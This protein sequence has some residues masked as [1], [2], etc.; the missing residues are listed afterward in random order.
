MLP[1]AECEQYSPT[2][3]ESNAG[4]V[5]FEQRDCGTDAIGLCLKHA[6]WQGAGCIARDK[7]II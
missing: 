5:P 1:N 7:V 3:S 6:R 4:N 2:H